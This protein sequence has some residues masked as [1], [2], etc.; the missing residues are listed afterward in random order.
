MADGFIPKHGGYQNLL[1]YKKAVIIYDGTYAFCERFLKPGDRTIGQM[2]QAARSGKQ[3]IVEGSQASG[4]SKETEIKLTSVARFSL[5]ELLEDYRDFLR[6]RGAPQWVK[7]SKEA[8]FVRKLGAARTSSYADFKPFI[9]TRPAE[10][11][12]NIMICVI[13][14]ANYLLDRQLKQLEQAFVKE[15]GLRERMM[16]ARLKERNRRDPA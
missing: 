6:L 16:K 10:T 9:D 5:Q 12:A 11:V 13:H 7:E 4:T 8:L 1:S 3:N 14:Q 15:G 2:Q